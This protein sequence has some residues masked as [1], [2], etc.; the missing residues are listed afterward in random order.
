MGGLGP[1]PQYRDRLRSGHEQSQPYMVTEV[2]SGGDVKGLVE[3]AR[4]NRGLPPISR[5]RWVTSACWRSSQTAPASR[6]RG[7]ASW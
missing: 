1:H 5:P 6:Q 7:E 2:I 4:E 3:M